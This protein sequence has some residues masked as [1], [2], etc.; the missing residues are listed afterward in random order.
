ADTLYVKGSPESVLA[1]CRRDQPTGQAAAA[2]HD[3][4]ERGLRVLAVATR[5][6]TDLGR[7]ADADE[8][9]LTLLGVVGMLDPPRPDA[10]EAVAACRAAGIRLALITGDHPGT[11]RA[12]AAQV[13]LLGAEPLVLNAADLPT[14]DAALAALV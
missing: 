1:A 8:R 14:D 12:I 13:G 3:M 10:A 4:A 11:A 9:D 5:T 7:G 2:A 6:G